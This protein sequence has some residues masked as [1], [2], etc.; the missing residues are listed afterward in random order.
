[1]ELTV[2]EAI[3]K[4]ENSIKKNGRRK[5]YVKGLRDALRYVKKIDTEKEDDFEEPNYFNECDPTSGM[6]TT[7]WRQ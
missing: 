3:E 7:E 1:M 2:K 5:Q 4:I 6:E